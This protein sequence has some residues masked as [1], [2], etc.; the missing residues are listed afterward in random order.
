MVLKFLK[1][2]LAGDIP[3]IVMYCIYGVPESSLFI[4]SINS[5]IVICCQTFSAGTFAVTS[6]MTGNAVVNVLKSD[7]SLSHCLTESSTASNM[8]EF[9]NC[10]STYNVKAAI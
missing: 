2:Y 5:M 3:A 7:V 8:S 4:E 6:L 10:Y 9:V 1:V